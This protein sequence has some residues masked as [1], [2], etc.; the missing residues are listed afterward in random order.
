MVLKIEKVSRNSFVQRTWNA[1]WYIGNIRGF[2]ETLNLFLSFFLF[3]VQNRAL[4]TSVFTIM[5][6][7]R[8]VDTSIYEADTSILTVLD[9]SICFLNSSRDVI[10]HSQSDVSWVP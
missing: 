2:P 6:R 7:F 8:G 4:T 3:K 10:Q 1:C 9:I 5:H